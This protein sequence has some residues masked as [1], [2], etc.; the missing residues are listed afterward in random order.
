MK[1]NDLYL[2]V[3]L[4]NAPPHVH[5]PRIFNVICIYIMLNANNASLSFLE[6]DI[7][8]CLMWCKIQRISQPALLPSKSTV[9]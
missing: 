1:N 9:S 5:K 7:T 4:V 3:F 2:P 6:C 8:S